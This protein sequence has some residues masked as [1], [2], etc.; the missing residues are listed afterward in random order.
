MLV[1]LHTSGPNLNECRAALSGGRVARNKMWQGTH[2]YAFDRHAITLFLKHANSNFF[3]P[4]LILTRATLVCLTWL[5]G[6]NPE[7][8]L[9]RFLEPRDGFL[10]LSKNLETKKK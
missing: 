6:V 7:L 3:P 4:F 8:I 10:T 9:L 2:T 1:A 5:V